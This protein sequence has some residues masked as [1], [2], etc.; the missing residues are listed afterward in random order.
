MKDR[1]VKSTI[2]KSA[3]PDAGTSAVLLSM[4]IAIENERL[5]SAAE[6]VG[7]RPAR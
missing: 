7:S 2:L 3:L 4:G 5:V 6:A 1:H